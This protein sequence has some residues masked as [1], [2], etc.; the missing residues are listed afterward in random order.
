[1]SDTTP[2]QDAAMSQ[3]DR[4]AILVIAALAL[5]CMVVLMVMRIATEEFTGF[6]MLLIVTVAGQLVS[7]A[8]IVKIDHQTNGTLTKRLDDQTAEV[9]AQVA[10]MLKTGAGT[11]VPE[12]STEE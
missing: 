3:L 2:A 6:A 10:D 8:K 7:H 12:H 4:I 5:V 1:M 9:V 11:Y